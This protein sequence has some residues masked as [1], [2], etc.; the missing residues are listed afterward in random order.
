MTSCIVL[1]QFY[2]KLVGECQ[3]EFEGNAAVMK[4]TVCRLRRKETAGQHQRALIKR[5]PALH[6]SQYQF[7]AR[8]IIGPPRRAAAARPPERQETESV[9]VTSP[10][11]LPF[12]VEVE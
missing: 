4:K 5:R 6:P 8:C 2:A 11:H 7:S 10:D 12:L 1:F 9:P 3:S